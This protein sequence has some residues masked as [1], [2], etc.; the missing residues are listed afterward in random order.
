MTNL[1]PPPPP[2]PAMP[3][4]GADIRGEHGSY[5]FVDAIKVCFAKYVTF[6]GRARRSEYWYWVLFQA[7]AGLVVGGWTIVPNLANMASGNASANAGGSLSQLVSLALFLPGLAVTVRRLHDVGKS[8]LWLIAPYVSFAIAL[9]AAVG[10]G[11]AA[12]VSAAESGDVS[13]GAGAGLIAASVFGLIGFA[14]FIP[15]IVWL[16]KDGGPNTANKYGTRD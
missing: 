6:K 11:I 2:M 4:G 7:L 14:L 12:L 16:C 13:A 1:P 8:G 9:V 5:T 15:I 3:S 10:S